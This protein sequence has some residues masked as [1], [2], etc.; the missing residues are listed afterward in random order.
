MFSLLA[1]HPL[2]HILTSAPL[3]KD[4]LPVDGELCLLVNI[5]FLIVNSL[6]NKTLFCIQEDQ[7]LRLSNMS[8][9]QPSPMLIVIMIMVVPSLIP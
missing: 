3:K 6:Q 7:L 8:E 4:A 2:L 5:S 9:Y 1:C